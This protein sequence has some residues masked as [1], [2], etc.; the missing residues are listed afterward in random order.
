MQI[1]GLK[2]PEQRRL[3]VRPRRRGEDK[4]HLQKQG[5]EYVTCI[6]MSE[7]NSHGGDRGKRD[8]VYVG[9][10]AA[11]VLRV[12]EWSKALVFNNHALTLARA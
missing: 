1:F 8:V 12:E 4:V 11:S 3:L 10:L 5:S 2:S 9:G 6:E 7:F